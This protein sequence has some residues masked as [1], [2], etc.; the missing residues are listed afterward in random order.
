ME[1][2]IQR[3]RLF[4]N[5]VYYLDLDGIVVDGIVVDGI[6]VDGIVLD[7]IVVD[8]IVVDGIVVMLLLCH[9]LYRLLLVLP[10]LA[11]TTISMI[12][13]SMNTK[14]KSGS[15]TKNHA[16]PVQSMLHK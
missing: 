15:R 5:H 2:E 12:N 3:I 1:S 4:F 11:R 8:G 13:S 10:F 6:V 9:Q 7:G 16:K 14:S